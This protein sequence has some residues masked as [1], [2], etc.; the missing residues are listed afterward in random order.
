MFPGSESLAANPMAAGGT[1]G[2]MSLAIGVMQ[3]TGVANLMPG[4]GA[5]GS[6]A[7]INSERI[8]MAHA[9]TYITFGPIQ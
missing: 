3:A 6:L 8:L 7:A 5:T 9:S 2:P 4:T 1:E